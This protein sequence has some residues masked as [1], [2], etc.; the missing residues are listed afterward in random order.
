[1]HPPSP[2]VALLYAQKTQPASRNPDKRTGSAINPQS[3]LKSSP[4][5]SA[6]FL[7]PLHSLS[8][9]P[10]PKIKSHNLIARV[11]CLMLTSICMHTI[12]ARTL[13]QDSDPCH[14]CPLFLFLYLTFTTSYLH[15]SFIFLFYLNIL[16]SYTPVLQP[17]L[18]I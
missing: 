18:T 2:L 15:Y 9:N 3:Q 16:I 10:L 4:S 14:C 8:F 17:L 1:M 6:C 5:A 7:P 11:T 13:V 12:N